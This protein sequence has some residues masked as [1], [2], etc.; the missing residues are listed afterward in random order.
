MSSAP[1]GN[2]KSTPAAKSWHLRRYEKALREAASIGLQETSAQEKALSPRERALKVLLLWLMVVSV[3]VLWDSS[4][5]FAWLESYA[6]NTSS[7]VRADRRPF[8]A[9]SDIIIVNLSDESFAPENPLRQPG[10]PVP[11]D[12]HAKLLDFL[13]SAGVKAIAFDFIFDVP[14]ETDNQ[15]LASI[16]RAQKRGTKVLL[17]CIPDES[18]R[19]LTANSALQK[20]NP[21][22]GHIQVLPEPNHPI[23]DRV[24][25]FLP[26]PNQKPIPAMSLQVARL[27]RDA[28]LLPPLHDD[29]TFSIRYAARAGE[30]FPYVPF[31][32][33]LNPGGEREFYLS[34]FKNKIVIVG[35]T[36]KIGLDFKE[37]PLGEMPGV[38]VQAH[39]MSTLLEG[40]F[41]RVAPFWQMALAVV[42]LTAPIAW[43]HDARRLRVLVLAVLCLWL[44]YS[45][46]YAWL[47]VERDYVLHL[48][49]PLGALL[50]VT[51]GVLIERGLYEERARQRMLD[52]LVIAASSAIES[53][54]PTT[55]GHSRR[56]TC[57][58][59]ELAIAV[60]TARAGKYRNVKFSRAEMKE[61]CY[62]ALLHDFGKIGVREAV[63][64]KSHKLEPMHFQAVKNRLLLLR[65]AQERDYWRKKAFLLQSEESDNEEKLLLFEEE[66]A[67]SL[68]QINSDIERLERANDPQVT[69]LPDAE[70]SALQELLA[71]LASQTYCDEH[72]QLRPILTSEEKTALM[73]RRG[74]L[75]EDEYRQIQNHA[76]LSYEFLRRIPWT[77]DYDQLAFIAWGHHEKLSGKGYP[78]GVKGD[79]IPLAT[80]MMTIADIYDALTAADR[81]YKKAMPLERALSILQ[82]EAEDGALDP[83]LLEIFISQ[84]I[85]EAT[86]DERSAWL[87]PQRQMSQNSRLEYSV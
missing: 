70:Y 78:R 24:P 29:Q 3:C 30:S 60:T 47:F 5:G 86:Q 8:K 12:H 17:A 59:L 61:L 35:D 87:F 31:E 83:D 20:A 66:H 64:V 42:L 23:I 33:I 51:L 55:A 1:D 19:W 82:K 62:S 39:A 73:I 58:T 76:Q 40:R 16:Q 2:A 68:E 52:A 7:S 22:I 77:K 81:P 45:L 79:E 63:L 56:V 49:A 4:D 41:E 6:Y 37:T 84:R 25:A 13:S 34:L 57:L 71:R 69:F 28:G 26:G 11:R 36:T 44:G 80:R 10:P 27:V 38:E 50:L 43:L 46:L 14:R 18:N 67:R 9:A 21:S 74:S 72:E 48:V 53:R 54:D 85:H 32:N 65:A 75:T 15:F